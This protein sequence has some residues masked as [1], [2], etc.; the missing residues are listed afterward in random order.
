MYIKRIIVLITLMAT[1]FTVSPCASFGAD[2][3]NI[4]VNEA[5]FLCGGEPISAVCVGDISCEVKISNRSSVKQK[6]IVVTG[7][8][9]GGRL[10]DVSF[11][12]AEISAG[13][14][15]FIIKTPAVQIDNVKCE[16]KT[17]VMGENLK[18]FSK[19]FEL[20]KNSEKRINSLKMKIGGHEFDGH[21]NTET[22]EIN[23]YVP[24]TYALG[25]FTSVTEKMT[26][27]IPCV[28]QADFKDAV[29][30]GIVCDI[31]SVGDVVGGDVPRDFSSPLELVV[32]AADKTTALYTVNLIETSM[33]KYQ[34]FSKENI[35]FDSTGLPLS[36]G[37]GGRCLWGLVN[38]S[39]ENS[40]LK[41]WSGVG[42]DNSFKLLKTNKTSD[43]D[44]YSCSGFNYSVFGYAKRAI[45]DIE[46]S[47]SD[48][49]DGDGMCISFFSTERDNN[50]NANLVFKK[51]NDSHMSMYWSTG[52]MGNG[53]KIKN[54]PLIGMGEFH[55]FTVIRTMNPQKQTN[56]KFE[57]TT[58][59]YVDGKF[60]A[61]FSD[62]NYTTANGETEF[63]P[64]KS[65]NAA[66]NHAAF[67]SVSKT[68]ENASTYILE[69]KSMEVYAEMY[70]NR[71]E[72]PE[73]Q[74]KLPED[75]DR[76]LTAL[77]DKFGFD[78]AM[79]IASL[80]DKE[81]GGFY[82]SVS[83][84]DYPY[85]APDIE[86]TSQAVS[87][88][89][90]S[91]LWDEEAEKEDMIPDWFVSG[92]TNFAKSRQN[93]EDGYFYDPQ[94][95]TKVGDSKKGRNLYQAIHLIGLTPG[96]S[97][98]YP[99]PAERLESA[100]LMSVTD[101][102]FESEEAC[103]LWLEDIFSKMSPYEAGN[104]VSASWTT[105]EASGLAG[106]TYDYVISKQNPQ[107]GLWGDKLDMAAI[108]GAM[109]CSVVCH[110]GPYPNFE[111]A[112]S[113]ITEIVKTYRPA[114]SADIWNPLALVDGINSSLKG[115]FSD[116]QW[117]MVD[118]FLGEML[119]SVNRNIDEFKKSDG[120]F[121]WY[122]T[123]SSPQSQ[124]AFVSMGLAEGDMNSTELARRVPYYACDLAGVDDPEFFTY[125]EKKT[126]WDA[127]KNAKPINKIP[128]ESLS[129]SYCDDFES[130]VLGDE[131]RI[132]YK[133]GNGKACVADAPGGGKAFSITGG[134][135]NTSG[136]FTVRVPE[137]YNRV[138]AKF[139]MYITG[140]KPELYVTLGSGRANGGAVSW[141]I[142]GNGESA[143]LCMRRSS[144][145]VEA[146][147]T[148]VSQDTWHSMEIVYSPHRM[149]DITEI[150]IDG[151]VVYKGNDYFVSGLNSDFPE[152]YTDG[153]SFT[154]YMSC[155]GNL[156]IDNIDY[157]FE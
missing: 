72:N 110:Y 130:G 86:S 142:F 151:K 23:V 131:W 62:T 55:R 26:Q 100:D 66:Y 157:C 80:Y 148:R 60:A 6:V 126:F 71:F 105:I 93:S 44:F 153:L 77:E 45:T 123:G 28:T 47:I 76:E 129:D 17:V 143:G 10:S 70:E 146:E 29:S 140:K 40:S 67:C 106:V 147:F 75:I 91:G 78:V 132:V 12:K 84:R 125:E 35:S 136:D 42:R 127:I 46:M 36:G 65:H 64:S 138:R 21:I 101:S 25:N 96:E 124:G 48:L 57:G 144:S 152:T 115:G 9:T 49:S 11:T 87:Y 108:N 103:L 83:S 68:E 73:I 3:V 92:L 63:S 1:L 54:A 74:R 102:R 34:D 134:G 135:D 32:M 5:K 2:S 139:D 56:R 15:G 98:L 41:A 81:T 20:A 16:C 99:L 95:G 33:R 150:V 141:C 156:L 112:L 121:S 104:E 13:K 155:S 120:G 38:Y 59:L 24:T 4:Y 109:K 8:Y 18:P 107:T 137:S 51:E 90:E 22:N 149:Q 14:T 85:F 154:T 58:E 119:K 116:E 19:A 117:I 50:K 113:S 88:L 39:E 122:K 79:W 52:G 111:K 53:V 61:S 128:L 89:T 82:Y 30:K 27:S 118:E 114:T 37:D 97:P 69:I 133:G 43:D 145:V 31:D 94:F 7:V